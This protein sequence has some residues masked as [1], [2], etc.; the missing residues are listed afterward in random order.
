LSPT[1]E[2]IAAGYTAS[3]DFPVT[4]GAFQPALAGATDA[5]VARFSAKFSPCDINA[6]QSI[7][8]S[9]VQLIVN[10]ALGVIPPSDDLNRDG[11]VNVSDV[12]IVINA[13]LGRGCSV[14]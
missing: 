13:A 4:S 2:F 12:Q 1:R 8:V 14:L 10:E 11:V 6:D 5:F 9:D 7:N 3:P